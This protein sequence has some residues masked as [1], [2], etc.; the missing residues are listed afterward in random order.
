M[1]EALK[2]I[3]YK[4]FAAINQNYTSGLLDA[5]CPLL[6]EKLFWIPLYVI[7][8]VFTIVKYKRNALYFI[9]GIAL[10]IL[11]S[12]Q[13]SASLIKPVFHRLRPCNNPSLAENVRLLVHCGSG[14]SFVSAHAS[15][16]FAMAIFASLTF[17]DKKWLMPV[18]LFWAFSVAYSQVYVGVHY[19]ADVVGG[20]IL[21]CTIGFVSVV[22]VKKIA[23]HYLPKP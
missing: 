10:A 5:V 19:P 3:D 16:H 2:E 12:D 4:I 21:G 15:N 13:I 18:L 11:L 8:G 9:A 6:R 17:G 1:T 23:A 7:G 22:A 14:F 20:G